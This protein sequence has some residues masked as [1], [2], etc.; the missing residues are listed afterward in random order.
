MNSID[1]LTGLGNRQGLTEYLASSPLST[2]SSR[3]WMALF[4]IDRFILVN[5]QH[6]HLIGDKYLCQM[7]K[8]L[9]A[10]AKNQVF[11]VFRV[12]GDGFVVIGTGMSPERFAWQMRKLQYSINKMKPPFQR[13]NKSSDRVTVSVSIRGISIPDMADP[14][15]LVAELDAVLGEAK[16]ASG[17][18]CG[19]FYALPIEA[20]AQILTDT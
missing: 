20:L 19:I 14:L 13:L 8:L 1:T 10:A 16:Y 7:S 4:D 9:S 17:T 5:D 6:G 11:A 15:K 12:S 18:P 3:T 2:A